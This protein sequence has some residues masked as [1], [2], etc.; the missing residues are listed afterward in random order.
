MTQ[1]TEDSLRESRLNRSS[2]KRRLA[3]TRNTG[4]GNTSKYVRKGTGINSGYSTKN[5]YS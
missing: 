1:A 2:L 4:K 3:E 5:K